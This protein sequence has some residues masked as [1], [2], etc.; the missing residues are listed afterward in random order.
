MPITLVRARL[1]AAP[2]EQTDADFWPVA[3][4]RVTEVPLDAVLAEFDVV[5]PADGL[6]EPP[7]L[8]GGAKVALQCTRL[9]ALERLAAFGA[10]PDIVFH[11]TLLTILDRHRMLRPTL[12]A[13]RAMDAGHRIEARD[14]AEETGGAGLAA[15]RKDTV[16][17]R[18]L[19]YDLPS[20][21]AID[22]GMIGERGEE[23]A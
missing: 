14:L 4:D 8:K 11:P 22:F 13:A 3:F 16:I 7:R 15:D 20:G 23:P 10:G 5:I 9:D 12:A 18:V 1:K 17:G 21:S 6:R 2:I 19:L